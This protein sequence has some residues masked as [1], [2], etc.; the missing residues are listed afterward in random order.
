[1][2]SRDLV[3]FLGLALAW[4]SSFLWIKIAVAEIGPFTLVALRLFFGVLGLSLVVWIGRPA[5]PKRRGEWITLAVLGLTNTAAPFV[6]ISWGE[7]FI[8]SAVAS[9]YNSTVPLFTVLIAHLFLREERFSLLRMIGVVIGF[10]GV[11]L[12]FARDL[13]QG[14]RLGLLGQ[15]AVLL[16]ALLYGASAVLT[17][18]NTKQI[19][20]R[21][22]ALLPLLVADSLAWGG[23][24]T[25]EAPLQLP[26]LPITW[27]AA[28]WLGLIGSFVAYLL[29]FHLVHNIGP[30]RAAMVTYTFPVSGLMLGALFLGEQISLNL[31][32]GSALVVGSLLIV[33]RVRR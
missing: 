2:K 20:R 32:A 25:V 16:A 4:G 17:R 21:L 7:Q 30:T 27:V 10:L 31:V 14:F 23:A 12:I 24:V 28:V 22:I 3:A 29:Y 13:A 26:Q 8:D 11:V 9:V 1:M 6:L 19:D 5:W 18:R 15:G 33:N